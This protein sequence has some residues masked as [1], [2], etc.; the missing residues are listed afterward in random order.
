MAVALS[1]SWI[2]VAVPTACAV[3]VAGA[4]AGGTV[5]VGATDEL[6]RLLRL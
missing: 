2:A 1:Q 3:E 4:G 6:R 5:D